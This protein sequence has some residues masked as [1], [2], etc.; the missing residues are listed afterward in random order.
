MLSLLIVLSDGITK[1]M[2]EFVSVVLI[3]GKLISYEF[4]GINSHCIVITNYYT[5]GQLINRVAKQNIG[6]L[7]CHFFS[8]HGLIFKA[9]E[10]WCNSQ[11]HQSPETERDIR[12]KKKKISETNQNIR[13]NQHC[14]TV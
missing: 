4:R 3:H 6:C 5:N 1:P 12:K 9:A 2:T 13:D 11:K 7:S 14:I 10:I 8:S